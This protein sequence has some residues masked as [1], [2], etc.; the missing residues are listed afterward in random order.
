MNPDDD[1]SSFNET[2]LP[3]LD[4]AYTL[5]RWLTHR[6]EDAQ[7]VVQEALVRALKYFSGYRGG[8]ARAWFLTIVRNTCYSWLQ[9]NRSQEGFICSIDA[10]PEP[11]EE[12]SNPE[13]WTLQSFHRQRIRQAVQE[14]PQEFREVIVLRE[15]EELDYKE[16][17]AVLGIPIGTVMSR[18]ARARTRLQQ[19]LDELKR[20]L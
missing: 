17:S 8:S 19:S 7:D 18:L 11:A 13:E 15:L 12:H 4:A 9:R 5:A 2:I 3:H 1:P 16:I 10:V 14:L 20:P 6:P